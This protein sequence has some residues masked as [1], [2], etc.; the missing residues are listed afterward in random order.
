MFA[1]FSG[2]HD[3][4]QLDGIF[5]TQEKADAALVEVSKIRD[6]AVISQI[7]VDELCGRKAIPHWRAT[8]NVATGELLFDK[9]DGSYRFY[10]GVSYNWEDAPY[11][12]LD[13]YVNVIQIIPYRHNGYIPKNFS[14]FSAKSQ[15]AAR[16]LA[17]AAWAELNRRLDLS[18]IY[19]ATG[20]IWYPK[21]LTE[22]LYEDG[23]C[24]FPSA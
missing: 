6:H 12:E 24:K 17:L 14:V 16:E 13:T 8:V 5:S 20:S 22:K 10:E 21:E 2:Q 19:H 1:I 23:V 7:V 3:D 15:E 18:K 11:P 4:H 9:E